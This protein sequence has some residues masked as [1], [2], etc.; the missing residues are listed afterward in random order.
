MKHTPPRCDPAF[1]R[2]LP[3]RLTLLLLLAGCATQDAGDAS[4]SSS[5]QR[6]VN[7]NLHA[8]YRRVQGSGW[9]GYENQGTFGVSAD[10]TPR[11]WPIGF[12]A[13]LFGS[14]RTREENDRDL[15]RTI[16]DVSLGVRK[17]VQLG[18]S[19]FRLYVGGGVSSVAAEQERLVSGFRT[20]DD[21]VSAAWYGHVGG[22]WRIAERF[23]VGIDARTTQNSELQLFGGEA[24]ADHWQVTAFFG[25]AW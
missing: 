1:P 14:A 15:D 12:E 24:D 10:V 20:S 3:A 19:P 13:A 2:R 5:R 6:I 4:G 11:R 25:W 16:S 7:A 9:D 8:G 18:S 21:D 17:T 22:Y 23:N